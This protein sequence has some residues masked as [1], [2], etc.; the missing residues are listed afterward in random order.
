[1]RKTHHFIVVVLISLLVA[2]AVLSPG[3]Q[4]R[5]AMLASEGRYEEAIALVQRQL[6][7]SPRNPD[8]LAALGRSYAALGEADRAIEA[9]DAYLEMRPE[10]L[11]ARSRQAGLMLRRG[12]M[13]RYLQ[14]QERLVAAQPSRQRITRLLELFRLQGRSEDETATLEAYAYKDMLDVPQ[15]ERLGAILAQRGHWGDARRWL[16]VA[17][18]KAPA[19]ASAGRLLLFEALIHD[20]ELDRIYER[21]NAWMEQ[22]RSAFLAGKLILRLSQAGLPEPAYRVAFRYMEIKPDDTFDIVGLL[23]DKGDPDLARDMLVRWA[24]RTTKPTG[25]QLRAFVQGSAWLGDFN[26]PFT[27]L[28]QIVRSGSDAA[29]QGQLA[30]EL[31]VSFGKPAL[32]AIRPLLSDEA[33]LTQPLFA[34]ELSMFE[35]NREMARWFLDRIDPAHL[36]PEQMSKWVALLH[37]V[38]PEA[39]AFGRLAMLWAEGRLPAEMLPDLADEAAK[40]DQIGMHDAIWNGIRQSAAAVATR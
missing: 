30:E 28:S 23:A 6:A 5:A 20:N 32:V 8:L 27:K 40:F 10:D 1:M 25:E 24:E 36:S 7:G 26:G 17:D 14:A 16:E 31:A 21:A 33:L 13:D 9:F 2:A 18:R 37:Q 12:L 15:L 38:Q 34:A 29:A 4:E 19:E 22:W 3:R 35:G 39:D 11:D